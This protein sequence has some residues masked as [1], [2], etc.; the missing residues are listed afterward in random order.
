M[1]T[2]N[3]EKPR[4]GYLT[5]YQYNGVWRKGIKFPEGKLSYYDQYDIVIEGITW[6]SPEQIDSENIILV[7]A[8]EDIVWNSRIGIYGSRGS[9]ASETVYLEGT[10]I[11]P[12]GGKKYTDLPVDS[13]NNAIGLTVK[14][15]EYDGVVLSGLNDRSQPVTIF[16]KDGENKPL[17]GFVIFH[18]STSTCIMFRKGDLTAFAAGYKLYYEDTFTT[19]SINLE[20]I[21]IRF[22][23]VGKNIRTEVRLVALDSNGAEGETLFRGRYN[24]G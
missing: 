6:Q 1:T 23:S 11:K 7:P 20:P 14:M 16:E 3:S 8:E 4:N 17:Q 12:F 18:G 13:A 10:E 22:E 21:H 24:Q 19:A 15:G 5:D 9:E 2:A